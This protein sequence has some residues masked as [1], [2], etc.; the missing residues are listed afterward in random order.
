MVKWVYF[1]VAV[2]AFLGIWASVRNMQRIKKCFNNGDIPV[3]LVA[4]APSRPIR[5]SPPE[6][7]TLRSPSTNIQFQFCLSLWKR[8]RDMLIAYS[9]YRHVRLTSAMSWIWPVRSQMFQLSFYIILRA[10]QIELYCNNRNLFDYI[11][12]LKI[13]AA[14]NIYLKICQRGR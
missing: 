9:G 4:S 5:P 14:D 2:L 6:A 13:Q 7:L 12:T 3:K 11:E 8:V 1:D 10:T